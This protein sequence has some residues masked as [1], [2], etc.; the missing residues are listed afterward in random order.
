MNISIETMETLSMLFACA[1]IILAI[2]Y[3]RKLKKQIN[4]VEKAFKELSMLYYEIK[5]KKENA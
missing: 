4:N 1:T 2:I 3:V 5:N